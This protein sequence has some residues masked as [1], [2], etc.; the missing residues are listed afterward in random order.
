MIECPPSVCDGFITG[1]TVLTTA[2]LIPELRLHL[3]TEVTPLWQASEE[4]AGTVGLPPP[5]WAFAWVGGQAVARH[6]LDHPELVRGRRVLD[7]AAGCGLIA[8]AA[9]RAGAATVTAV[10]IDSFALAAIRLNAAANGLAVTVSAE[11]VVGPRRCGAEVILAGD[12]CYERPMAEAVIAWLRHEA[13]GGVTVIIG[14]PGRS[15]LPRTGLTALARHL[16]R[17]I[18]DVED[19]DVKSTTVWRVEA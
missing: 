4:T 6:I 14:D 12:V 18:S 7:F 16:I 5:Y 8:L 15:Y 10:D 17:T 11:D 3:A 1:H 9:A 2:P 19:T 13:A